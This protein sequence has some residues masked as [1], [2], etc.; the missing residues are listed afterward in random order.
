[1]MKRWHEEVHITYRNWRN[2]R[3]FHVESN[4]DHGSQNEPGKDPFEVDCECDN[5]RGRFRK[6]DAY[7]CGNT[8]CCLCH[9]DKFPKRDK[10]YQEKR[11]ELKHKEGIIELEEA[12]GGCLTNEIRHNNERGRKEEVEGF[13]G[14]DSLREDQ[15][16]PSG[17]GR[18]QAA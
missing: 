5:Q 12:V 3:R 11:A 16:P 4:I 14:Q 7:D 18:D 15:S 8:R 6:K 13:T 9:S 1:M 2:H 17:T 10:T